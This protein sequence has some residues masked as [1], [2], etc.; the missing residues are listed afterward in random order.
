MSDHNGKYN[1]KAVSNILGIHPG[2]LRAWERRY[3]IIEPVRNDAGHR[4][5]TDEQMKVLKWIIDKVDQ[6]FTIGQAVELLDKQDVLEDMN[7]EAIN[8]TQLEAFQQDLLQSLLQFDEHKANRLL[9]QA[10]N[11]FSIE[12]VVIS[13]LGGILIDVGDKWERNEISIAHEHYVT[14]YLRTK[15]GMVFHQLPVN[16]LLPKVVCVCGPNEQHEIG[17]L[18]FTF[19]LRR[20]GYETIYLGSGIPEKDICLVVEETMPKL[21]VISC[22]IVD[23]LSDTLRVANQLTENFSELKVG[24]GGHAVNNLS[25]SGHAI[26]KP[27]LIGHTEE[28]W[29]Q[30]LKSNL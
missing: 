13:V 21:I 22:T 23:H 24:I 30:W 7:H 26:Y 14:S 19:F 12:K 20:R 28:Q 29:L 25:Q 6:G 3:K 2:T 8:K 4:L 15:I 27:Y 1:I 17:L 18:I 5:Y 11:V 16:S 10:F 9:D